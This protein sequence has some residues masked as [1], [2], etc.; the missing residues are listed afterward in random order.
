MT[1]SSSAWHL[2]NFVA[3]PGSG[4]QSP[5]RAMVRLWTEP[6]IE[7]YQRYV[8]IATAEAPE[9]AE[10]IQMNCAAVVLERMAANPIE[11]SVAA[12]LLE[13]LRKSFSGRL[14]NGFIQCGLSHLGRDSA[15]DPRLAEILSSTLHRFPVMHDA[16]PAADALARL[17]ELGLPVPVMVDFRKPGLFDIF[18]DLIADERPDLVQRIAPLR[19]KNE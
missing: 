5:L 6:S 18:L 3:L 17:H 8:E 11:P 13:R 15:A 19:P 9:W 16:V 1:T 12:E 4:L 2:N 14:G 7:A 10:H